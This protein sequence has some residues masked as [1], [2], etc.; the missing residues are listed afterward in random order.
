MNL[1]EIQIN[2]SLRSGWQALDLGFL[3]AR[4]WWRP[5]V[6]ASALPIIIFL[7]P[8]L[9]L[10][11]DQPL[12]VGF[13]IWWLKPVWERLP[14][15]LASR[16]L[17]ADQ[18]TLGKL[19][20]QAIRELKFDLLP[21]LLWRRL[22]LQRGFDA[23]VSV[24]EKLKGEPRS[25]RLKVLHGKYSE[26]GLANQVVCFCFE[27]IVAIGIITLLT[28]F[29]ENLIEQPE[30]RSLDEFS[31]IAEWTYL[32]A[33]LIAMVLI[34]PFHIMAGFS[35]YLNR[36]IELEAWDIEIAFRNIANRNAAKSKH[37]AGGFVTSLLVAA[38]M[39]SLISFAPPVAA[40]TQHDQKS[41]AELIGE[42]LATDSFGDEKTIQMWRI[43][44][45]GLDEEDE[46]ATLFPEWLIDFLEA[47]TNNTS[48]FDGIGV[49]AGLVKIALIFTFVFI[50]FYLLRRYRGPLAMFRRPVRVVDP[51]KTL[52]G[53]DL[54]PESLPT[55]VPV[56]VMEL[57]QKAQSREALSLLYRASLSRLIEKYSIRFEASHTEVEC[58]R[59]VDQRGVD[60]LSHYFNG[61][62]LVW[63]NLAYGHQLPTTD[64][65]VELCADWQQEMSNATD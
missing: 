33:G 31:V 47:L 52:F 61:L 27:I 54:R 36:R 13:I 4:A 65:V 39:L 19:Q 2:P 23:A 42:V 59:L 8:M 64:S 20:A 45:F 48:W 5:L 3:M 1:D 49:A 38:V 46:E 63:R 11:Y 55:D 50:V 15:Y 30:F 34:M 40:T 26:V 6:L 12:W 16:R 29:S 44:W 9:V 14:L 62:T 51:P 25:S 57:W 10:L 43:N 37:A 7:L 18:A 56:A 21:M 28:F 35:L 24:L 17:F 60:S 58:A 41:A 32:L 53:L 22:S